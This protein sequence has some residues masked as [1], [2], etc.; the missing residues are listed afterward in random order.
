MLKQGH[1][2]SH[3]SGRNPLIR[4]IARGDKAAFA[5]FYDL[6]SPLAFPFAVR[7]LRNRTEAED[8]LRE[9][10]VQVWKSAASYD[11]ARGNPEA[12]ISTITRS[13]AIDK[14]R[15]RRRR[16]GSAESMERHLA[17]DRAEAG[18]RRSSSD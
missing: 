11:P 4:Q 13:R 16:D 14:L 17:G 6:Y 9:V 15:S 7:L 5:R 18:Q 2:A 3:R 12:W 1:G 8:L 10:F